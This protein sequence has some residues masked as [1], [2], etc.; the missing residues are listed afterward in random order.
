MKS[1]DKR[2]VVQQPSSHTSAGTGHAPS[3]YLHRIQKSGSQPMV[4]GAEGHC[5]SF[6][7]IEPRAESEAPLESLAGHRA[8]QSKFWGPQWLRQFYGRRA[9]FGSFCWKTPM[10][11]KFLVFGGGGFE[12][13]GGSVYA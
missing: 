12:R 8:I 9:F 10:P 11:I 2:L 13:G 7:H 3:S 1:S 6:L 5:A 4:Q